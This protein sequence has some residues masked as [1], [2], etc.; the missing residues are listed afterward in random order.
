MPS[1]WISM[2]LLPGVVNMR[3]LSVLQF[4]EEGIRP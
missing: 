2:T 1:I 3:Q 4:A